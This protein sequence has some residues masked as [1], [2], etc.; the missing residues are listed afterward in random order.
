M[1]ARRRRARP[2]R[3]T[4]RGSELATVT[5]IRDRASARAFAVP[6]RRCRRRALGR[7]SP[8]ERLEVHLLEL[9]CWVTEAAVNFA[10]VPLAV[11]LAQLR[12]AREL[13][14]RLR[15]GLDVAAFDDLAAVP[16]LDPFLH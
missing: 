15:H 8:A 9:L 12:V 6:L 4:W 1:R 14:H 7:A 3:T 2:A 11:A 5:R 13:E 10:E 16:R